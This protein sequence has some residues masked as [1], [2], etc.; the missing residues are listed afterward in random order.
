MRR[1][2][3]GVLLLLAGLLVGGTGR[4]EP[5]KDQPDPEKGVEVKIADLEDFVAKTKL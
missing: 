4:S 3:L 1:V 5:V 2:R